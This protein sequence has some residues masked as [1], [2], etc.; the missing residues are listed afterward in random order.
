M[1]LELWLSLGLSLVV[2]ALLTPLLRP[3]LLRRRMIDWPEERR[4]HQQPT[5]RGGG[6]A[7]WLG[8][9][10]GLVWAAD[11]NLSTLFILKFATVLALLGWLD[12]SRSVPVGVRLLVM[13]AAALGLVVFYG[14]VSS[15]DMRA[16]QFHGPWV[17]SILGL[18]AV[19]W[20]INLHNFMDGS[21]GLAAAQGT[22]ASGLLGGLLYSGGEVSVG[23]AGLAMA[24][25]SL[26]FLLWNR[27]PARLFM[28]DVG[29][30][31]LGGMIGL[32][33][34]VGAA[35]GILSIWLSLIVCSVFV[36]DATAT[37]L[38]RGLTQGQWYTAHREHAYQRLMTAGCGHGQVWLIYA[39]LNMLLVLPSV[40]LALA[41]PERQMLIALAL[42]AILVGLWA[43]V[44]RRTQ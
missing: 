13:L 18:I 36:V 30:L 12:D 40:I 1:P 16:W 10:I 34:Y 23:L 41:W 24:G 35:S 22:W 31:M 42:T 11:L 2:T 15:L 28:G 19:V 29:S 14:P 5:P 20:L 6:L 32:L 3:W 37:L 21:D 7:M 9:V 39:A 43:V 8:L 44:Q 33:A 26:G 4:S 25:A 27:P 17:L 38:R